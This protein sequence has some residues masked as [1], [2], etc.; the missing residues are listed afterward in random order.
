MRDSMRIRR[1]FESLSLRFVSRC[2]RT[3]TA[4][5]TRCQ[6]SSGIDGARPTFVPALARVN[7]DKEARRTARLEDTKDF[8]TG[9]EADL[10]DAVRVTECDTDL[11]RRQALAGELRDL[12][13]NVLRARLK[14]GR[15][16][17]AVRKGRGRCV[18]ARALFRICCRTADASNVQMP[19]PGACMRPM[20]AL[21]PEAVSN[22]QQQNGKSTHRFY[23]LRRALAGAWVLLRRPRDTMSSITCS[24]LGICCCLQDHVACAVQL[25][26]ST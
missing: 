6:R 7:I 23:W 16:S 26:T 17:A 14:P 10:R 4:F 25:L 22:D 5:L 20:A 13:Y 11:G 8:V 1:N 9:D 2:L 12:V 15:R 19:F 24:K 18:S 21:S 3:A